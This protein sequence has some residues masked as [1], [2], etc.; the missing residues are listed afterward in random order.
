M[1]SPVRVM[2]VDDHKLVRAGIKALLA[3]IPGLEVVSEADNG[4]QALSYL[5]SHEVDVVLMDIAMPELNGI[6]ATSFI[7]QKYPLIK[8]IILSMYSNAEYVGRAL[9]AGASGYLLKDAVPV[10]LELAINSVVAGGTY[11]SPSVSH[12]VVEN[13]LT[14]QERVQDVDRL[15][16]RQREIWQLIAE[17]CTSKEIAA[18]LGISV[19]TVETHRQQ[20]MEKLGAHDLAGLVRKAITSGLISP[21]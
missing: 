15:T 20:L 13:F 21:Q 17:G 4:R 3:Q 18:K 16:P 19:K 8:V 14:G 2:I 6:D 11:L 7:K 9:R 1:P 10:E 12:H 5:S